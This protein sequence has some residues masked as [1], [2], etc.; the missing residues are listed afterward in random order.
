M[1]NR[2]RVVGT[3]GTLENPVATHCSTKEPLIRS[4]PEVVRKKMVREGCTLEYWK[5]DV[6]LDA[7]TS[8]EILLGQTERVV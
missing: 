6:A 3:E 1:C 5:K 7:F 2:T 4:K 8:A